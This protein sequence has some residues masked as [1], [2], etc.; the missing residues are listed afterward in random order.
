MTAGD[1]KGDEATVEVLTAG[2][3]IVKGQLVHYETDGKYDPAVEDDLGPFAVAIDAAAADA[4]T[5]RAVTYGRVEVALEGTG[6]ALVGSPLKAGLTTTNN[7][8]AGTVCLA[9]PDS[10]GNYVCGV[11]AE[12]ADTSGNLLTMWVGRR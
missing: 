2:A 3:V 6:N 8:P 9:V 10:S 11:A 7:S 1:I 12:A 5:F 4:A